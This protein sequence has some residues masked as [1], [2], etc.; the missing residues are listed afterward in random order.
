MSHPL[1]NLWIMERHTDC[2]HV[3]VWAGKVAVIAC[4]DCSRVE[5]FSASGPIDPAE[6]MAAL[7]GS[8]DLIGPMDAL[9]APTSQVL[10]YQPPSTRKRANLKTMPR[11]VWLKAGPHL[12]M[13]HDG[14]VLLLAPTSPLVFENLIRP[15]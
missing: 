15:A 7:F 10:V 5:W 13:S 14:E 11:R 3:P 12:W 1:R 6:G 9:G 2:D 4:G 8:Y